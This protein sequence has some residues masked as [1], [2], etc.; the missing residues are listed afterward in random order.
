MLG[1]YVGETE[2]KI[3]AAFASAARRGAVLLIDEADGF[4]H[5]RDEAQQAGR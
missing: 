3:A 4:P 5:R 1:P 2:A